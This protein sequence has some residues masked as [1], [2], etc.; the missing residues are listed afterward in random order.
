MQLVLKANTFQPVSL[1]GLHQV[2]KTYLKT[3]NPLF[4]RLGKYF[5]LQFKQTAFYDFFLIAAS[6]PQ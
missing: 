3:Y 6:D 5:K 4:S 2:K 1:I